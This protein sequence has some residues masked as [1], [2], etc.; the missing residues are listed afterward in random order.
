MQKKILKNIEQD[1]GEALRSFIT[2]NK[3]RKTKKIT[4]IENNNLAPVFNSIL[5]SLLITTH[6]ALSRILDPSKSRDDTKNHLLYFG[7]FNNS[8]LDQVTKDI[9]TLRTIRD[10]NIA[11]N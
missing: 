7:A 3:L 6:M 4:L 5:R 8:E 2:F 10:K 11:H 9:K 1:F